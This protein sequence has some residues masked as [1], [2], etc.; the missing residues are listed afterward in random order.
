VTASGIAIV[1]PSRAI[2]GHLPKRYDAWCGHKLS[3]Q[4]IDGW[5]VALREHCERCAELILELA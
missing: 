3:V 4:L 5:I 1:R 2:I